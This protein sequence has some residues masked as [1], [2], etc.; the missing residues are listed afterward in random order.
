MFPEG[1]PG[2]RG[3]RPAGFPGG[4]RMP[5][6]MDQAARYSSKLPIGNKRWPPTK[7]EESLV[8]NFE[9]KFI[10]DP[11]CRF[12]LDVQMVDNYLVLVGAFKK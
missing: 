4:P 2:P 1:A 9:W 11:L 10:L 12:K 3:P 5:G 8:F 6:P 7:S